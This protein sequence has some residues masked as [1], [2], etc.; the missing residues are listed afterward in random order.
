MHDMTSTFGR[1]RGLARVAGAVLLAAS[2]GT[3]SLG[4]GPQREVPFANGYPV[5]PD[6]LEARPL[7]ADPVEYD[8]AEG[9]HIR[10]SVVTRDLEFP[11]SLA[12]L[13]D[14]TMLV[15]ERGGDLHVIRDGQ[16]DPEPVAGVPESF[17]D[18]RSGLPAAVHGLMDVVLHPEFTENRLVY[19]GYTKP[20]PDGT[21]TLAVA[22][23]R[24]D[25]DVR[26]LEEVEDIF[27]A[28]LG[29]TSKMA[30]GADGLLYVTTTGDDPQDP[31]TLGGKVLRLNDDGSVPDD[32]PFVGRAGPRPEVYT[33]GHRNALGLA[34]HPGTGVM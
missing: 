34:P 31:G 15:T 22:R 5:A 33:L 32:N 27:V 28:G 6:G 19:L 16:L 7:P 4:A 17:S 8:T 25:A 11:F 14:S 10:V 20:L 29:A 30:F 9:L 23:G 18:G 2:A 26:R 24:L 21:R 12:F 1:R 3:L 13:P